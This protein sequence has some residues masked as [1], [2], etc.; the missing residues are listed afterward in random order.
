MKIGILG[1]KGIP[2]RHGVENVVDS[3]VPHLTSRG[4]EVTTYG[5]ETYTNNTDDYFGARIKTVRGS[6]GKNMEMISHM[7]NACLDARAEEFDIV[8]IH[9]TDPCLLGW[10]PNPRCALIATSHGQAYLRNKW[11]FPAKAMSRVAERFFI[12]LP[13]VVTS[14]SKPLADY[15]SAKYG[16]EVLHI[17]NGVKIR[18]KPSSNLIRKWAI[19]PIGYLFCSAG[20]I[21]RTKGLHTLLEAYRA[22]QQK[23]PLVIAGGGPGT[24]PV[25]FEELKRTKPP[26]VK[27]VGFLTGDDLFALYGHARVFVFP[28]EYEAMSMALLEGLSYGVPTIYSNIPENEAVAR[29]MGYSFKVSDTSSLADQLSRVLN[30]YDDATRISARARQHIRTNH[31]WTRIAEQYHE[32]YMHFAGGWSNSRKRASNGTGVRRYDLAAQLSAMGDNRRR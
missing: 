8:H 6:P 3:L 25:Y 12:Q 10:L 18:E 24:D 14:V 9:N 28:S 22:I 21:E 29:G 17:P 31:D 23:I 16:R 19:E 1:T 27:F 11:S 5:Y 26:G 20:R 32:L 15:Y 7:L 30:R 2:G 13:D 4:H